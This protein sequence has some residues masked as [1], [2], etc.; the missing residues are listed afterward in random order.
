MSAFKV[1]L[2]GACGSGKTTFLTRHKTGKFLTSYVP[3]I[4]PQMT[5][6]I[7][8]TEV[9]DTVLNIWDVGGTHSPHD[10]IYS[11]ADAFIVFIDLSSPDSSIAK[12]KEYINEIRKIRGND[13]KI[14]ILGN[15][16]E[17]ESCRTSQL[18]Q[19]KIANDFRYFPIS[20][21][22]NID[23][24]KVFLYLVRLLN[25]DKERQLLLQKSFVEAKKDLQRA[26]IAMEAEIKKTTKAPSKIILMEMVEKMIEN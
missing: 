16:C 8:P 21:K 20:V 15:K 22:R 26:L 25:G 18:H 7:F 11:G 5:S 19:Q 17:V 1:V 10:T 9:G 6:L 13:A 23:L 24:E 14:V 2:L 4:D 12:M 3:T